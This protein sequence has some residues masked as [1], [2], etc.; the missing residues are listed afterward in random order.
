M[1]KRWQDPEYKNKT[2]QAIRMSFN[3]RWSNPN[4][5]KKMIKVLT[6]FNG[7]SNLERRVAKIASKY[8]FQPSIAVGRYL[9]DIMN[10]SKKIIVE[11]NGDYWHCNPQFWKPND[12]HSF[13]KKTAQ[14]VWDSDHKRKCYLESLGYSVHV[15]WEQDIIKGKEQ[16]IIDFFESIK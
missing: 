5:R 6:S 13:K 1:K 3:T 10:A 14:D 8:G 7:V 2:N 16:F 12:V 15:I 4:T 11:V 9:A